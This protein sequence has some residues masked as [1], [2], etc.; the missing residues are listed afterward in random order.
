MVSFDSRGIVNK[1]RVLLLAQFPQKALYFTAAQIMMLDM[2]TSCF[3]FLVD[4]TRSVIDIAIPSVGLLDYRSILPT[5][6]MK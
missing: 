3:S 1:V 2:L 6:K 5:C 4:V